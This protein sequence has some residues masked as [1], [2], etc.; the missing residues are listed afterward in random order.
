MLAGPAKKHAANVPD[1]LPVLLFLREH[2][3]AIAENKD[4]ALDQA[5]EADLKE[6]KQKPAP[7]WFATRLAAGD[8]LVMLDGLD[9]VADS[10]QREQVSKWVERQLVIYPKNIFIVTSRPMAIAATPLPA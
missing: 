3:A 8:C 4:Y 7:E 2:A 1:K 9:E 10:A 6:F 5:I